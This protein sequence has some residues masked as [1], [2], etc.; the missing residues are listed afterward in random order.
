MKSIGRQMA[1]GLVISIFVIE[2]KC[3]YRKDF[4]YADY[5]HQNQK[6]L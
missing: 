3:T 5:R 6:I 4:S 1:D 2:N